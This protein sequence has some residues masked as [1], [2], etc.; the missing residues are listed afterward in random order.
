MR[1][2]QPIP[3]P[4]RG[5]ITRCSKGRVRWGI[6]ELNG[7][8][9]CDEFGIA[10]GILEQ[11]RNVEGGSSGADNGDFASLEAGEI[12]VLELWESRVSGSVRNTGG[13]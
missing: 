10:A 13:T 6:V 2:R 11:R 12:A 1:D 7:L 5:S 4:E 3:K 9:P 8:G